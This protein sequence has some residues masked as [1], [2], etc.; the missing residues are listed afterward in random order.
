MELYLNWMQGGSVNLDGGDFLYYTEG[1]SWIT[2]ILVIWQ[3]LM[4]N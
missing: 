2:H 3:V 4:N 1:I